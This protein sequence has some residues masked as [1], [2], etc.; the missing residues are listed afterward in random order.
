M[1]GTIALA[2]GA[3]CA[4]SATAVVPLRR[5]AVRWNLTDDPGGHK[6]HARPTPY[7]GG[8][9]IVTGTVVP[10]LVALGLA[11]LQI[12]AI[13]LAAAA[14]SVLG[15]IDDIAPL[16]AVTRLAVETV[17]AIGV[18]LSGVQATV[19]GTWLD[20]VLTVV[21]IVVMTNSF[22]LL[23]NMD[24]ALGTVTAVTAALLAAT[25]L[26][27][28]HTALALL[29]CALT[30]ACLGFL[31]YNWEPARVFMGDSGSLFIGFTLACSAAVLSG[32]RSPD[33]TVAGLFL[34]TFLATLDTCVV[35]VS[36]MLAGR[37]PL[38]GGTDH[39]SHR[40]RRAGLGVRAV[41][42]ALGAIAAISGALCLAMVLDRVS[43]LVAT[44]AA[45]A[46]AVVLTC[47]LRDGR[48]RPRIPALS[49]EPLPKIRERRH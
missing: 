3:A 5:L 4:L 23:D 26:A 35:F 20:G 42:A 16:R 36:R 8:I 1:S 48:G 15:L 34:P 29:L 24:G 39:V 21:W 14:V 47:L 13:L 11:D 31:P 45:C 7:V 12:T 49:S 28:G 19:T 37:S 6:V 25:A 46:I 38:Q 2:S 30:C 10:T 9:A 32:G 44:A 33:A 27:Q 18:V 40:L 17:V 41:A 22:N 43:P